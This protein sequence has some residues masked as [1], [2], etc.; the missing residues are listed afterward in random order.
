MHQH[1]NTRTNTHTNARTHARLTRKPHLKVCERGKIPGMFSRLLLLLLQAHFVARYSCP[2]I[3]R[4]QLSGG[5]EHRVAGYFQE[6]KKFSDKT[7]Q[8]G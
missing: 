6:F 2:K 1:T 8:P 3:S 4:N 7:K 5:G